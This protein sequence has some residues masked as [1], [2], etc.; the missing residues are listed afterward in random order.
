[1]LGL[2]PHISEWTLNPVPQLA[3]WTIGLSYLLTV[4]ERI[5]EA[6]LGLLLSEFT[7]WRQEVKER[8]SQPAPQADLWRF[9]TCPQ[10]N[11][12]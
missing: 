6:I 1:M 4:E 2:I 10:P 12:A 5:E 9:K 8:S 11:R 3:S 7:P